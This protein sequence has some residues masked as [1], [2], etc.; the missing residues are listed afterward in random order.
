M[1]KYSSFSLF[2]VTV[3]NNFFFNS[4]LVGGAESVGVSASCSSE[5]PHQ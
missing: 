4:G 5:E 3:F 1:K 2:Y